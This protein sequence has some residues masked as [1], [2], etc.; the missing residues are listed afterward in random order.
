MTEPQKIFENPAEAPAPS[1]HVTRGT[2]KKKAD[3]N[4]PTPDSDWQPGWKPRK[5]PTDPEK[6][7]AIQ[8]NARAVF[9]GSYT[10]P[11]GVPTHKPGTPWDA[12]LLRSVIDHVRGGGGIRDAA[13]FFGV[14]YITLYNALA[15]AGLMPELEDARRVAADALVEQALHYATEP[16]MAIETT[17]VDTGEKQVV[18]T[19]CFDNV[20]ARKLAYEARMKIASKWAPD[21][22]GD[23]IELKTDVSTA[24]AIAAAR[25]RL[26][27][28]VVDVEPA[29]KD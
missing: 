13:E 29:E 3:P 16:Q 21:R 18:T 10:P 1:K 22:Y 6:R 2:R 24:S 28:D 25:R 23:K 12:R 26:A 17:T 14:P 4:A 9:T 19:R 20:Y 8:A 15:R 5:R 27:P 7:R 11:V